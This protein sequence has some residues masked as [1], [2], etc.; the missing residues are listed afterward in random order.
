MKHGFVTLA[1]LSLAVVCYALG[2]EGSK[3]LSWLLFL[4]GAGFELAFWVR[5]LGKRRSQ[6]QE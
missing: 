2:F 5:L 3:P 1:F 4:L 6:S